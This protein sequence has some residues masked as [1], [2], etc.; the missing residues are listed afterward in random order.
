MVQ[1]GSGRVVAGRPL[2][3]IVGAL[4]G[5]L[6]IETER[7]EWAREHKAQM[8]ARAA[9]LAAH[10]ALVESLTDPDAPPPGAAADAESFLAG[11]DPE[12]MNKALRRMVGEGE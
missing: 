11:I 9:E 8:E 6:A 1:I 7:Q 4:E 5:L 12:L 2:D 10:R 3:R